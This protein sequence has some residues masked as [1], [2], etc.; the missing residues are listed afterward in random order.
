MSSYKVLCNDQ[1]QAWKNGGLSNACT[2]QNKLTDALRSYYGFTSFRPGQLEALLPV[3]HGQDTFVR[4]PTGG[5]K[6]L[7]MFLVP[8]SI[9]CDAMGIFIS[10][11]VGLIQ[12]QV[13]TFLLIL[14]P[15]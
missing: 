13:C 9:S 6:T 8:L 10:P 15:F 7:C 4:M 1:C 2:A 11:L 5:G 3:A 12:Q 14:F